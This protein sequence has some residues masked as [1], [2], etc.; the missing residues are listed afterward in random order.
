MRSK[1]L[2][3]KKRHTKRN[4]YRGGVRSNTSRIS[5]TKSTMN[6]SNR[7]SHSR[8]SRIR[9]SNNRYINENGLKITKKLIQHCDRGEWEDYENVILE[10][11]NDHRNGK[12][13]FFEYMNH[14]NI[15]KLDNHSIF[16]LEDAFT[17]LQEEAVDVSM[18]YVKYV[19]EMARKHPEEREQVREHRRKTILK[20]Y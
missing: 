5:K 6:K 3:Y 11:L 12:N 4:K 16:C 20:L 18:D 1:S 19:W 8:V 7:L 17:R 2:K 9:A 14:N 10:I 15:K 13:D